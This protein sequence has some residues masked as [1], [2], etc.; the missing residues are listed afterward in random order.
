MTGRPPRYMAE[1]AD[2]ILQEVARGRALGEIC[3]EPGMPC[4]TTVRQWVADDIE[5]FAARY[6]QA[7]EIGEPLV[8]H[9]SSD[10]AGIGE[11]IAGDITGGSPLADLCSEPG[12]PPQGMIRPWIVDSR[13]D[14]TE[15]TRRA[16]EIGRALSGGPIP[17]CA[18][19]ADR[20]LGEL[21]EGRTLIEACR[22]PG[23]PS[24][25]TVLLWVRRNH[26]G[27]AARYREARE[28]GGHIMADKLILIG[29][30]SRGDY[31]TRRTADGETIVVVDRDNIE[32]DRLRSE[33]LKWA[34]TRALPRIYGDRLQIDAKHDASDGWAELLK[35]LDGKTRGLP[36]ED[37]PCD[38]Q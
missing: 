20:V 38:E 32:R 27:F 9:P 7:R 4:E 14:F 1:L 8:R 33:N 21:M 12:M 6:G 22:L 16:E 17:Y 37:E 34:L 18:E 24:E 30:D 29:D 5:G 10:A 23:I 3:A 19:L 26:D 28:I 31:V 11:G 13:E 2:R 35:E 36:S 15:R 25:G